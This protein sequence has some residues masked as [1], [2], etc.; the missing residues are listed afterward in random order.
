[1]RT[2]RDYFSER[3]TRCGHVGVRRNAV[4]CDYYANVRYPT[5][6]RCKVVRSSNL[7]SGVRV[8]KTTGTKPSAEIAQMRAFSHRKSEP[9]NR[10]SA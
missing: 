1:M 6:D 10:T 5:R 7:H 9:Q 2:V 8:E 4:S 3:A